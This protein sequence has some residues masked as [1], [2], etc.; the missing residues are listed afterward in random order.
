MPVGNFKGHAPES[1]VLGVARFI[2]SANRFVAWEYSIL[3]SLLAGDAPSGLER[4][5]AYSWRLGS[6]H[7]EQK[8]I[9]IWKKGDAT[10]A[11]L[12]SPLAFSGLAIL[13]AAMRDSCTVF[14][15]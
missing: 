15:G 7:E 9:A 8:L 2:R 14:P 13:R 4:V 6:G 10:L 1:R 3:L 11:P 5:L 12:P